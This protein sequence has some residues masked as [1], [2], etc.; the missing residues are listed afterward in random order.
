MSSAIGGVISTSTSQVPTA[1]RQYWGRTRTP[2]S[3]LL[4]GSRRSNLYI[5]RSPI[6]H[7]CLNYVISMAVRWWQLQAL[8]DHLRSSRTAWMMTSFRSWMR[9]FDC[10]SAVLWMLWSGRLYW[11]LSPSAGPRWLSFSAGLTQNTPLNRRPV[12]KYL[13]S[14]EQKRGSD[15]KSPI[16]MKHWQKQHWWKAGDRFLFHVFP[17]SLSCTRF[18]SRLLLWEQF[19]FIQCKS[20]M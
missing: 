1:E 5:L 12:E 17:A 19:T 14:D 4:G 2:S 8:D 13:P 9:R 15:N 10:V 3:A 18:L 20:T 16:I 11:T 6:R 7:H